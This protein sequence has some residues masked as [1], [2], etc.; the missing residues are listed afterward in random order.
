MYYR[1]AQDALCLS[2]KIHSFTALP[3]GWCYGE[4]RAPDLGQVTVAVQVAAIL[5]NINAQRLNAFPGVDGSVILNSD[6]DGIYHEFLCRSDKEIEVSSESDL[7]SENIVNVHGLYELLGDKPWRDSFAS[8][9]RATTT[10][11]AN[12][13]FHPHSAG[14]ERIRVSPL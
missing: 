3:S 14:Q 9:T 12:D 2:S 8:Y 13:S 7:D 4:G 11:S 6:I 10:K 1:E 5:C